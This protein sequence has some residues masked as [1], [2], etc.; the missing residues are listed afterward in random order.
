MR[1]G[2]SVSLVHGGI[3]HVGKYLT[4]RRCCP[5]KDDT[6]ME[7]IMGSE[8]ADPAAGPEVGKVMVGVSVVQISPGRGCW[9]SAFTCSLPLSLP[10]SLLCAFIHSANGNEQY[11]CGG[12][13][14]QP[15]HF[16]G[17]LKHQVEEES[18]QRPCG[19]ETGQVWKT[20]AGFRVKSGGVG[21]ERRRKEE[22]KK[23]EGDGGR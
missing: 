5:R 13:R 20:S 9:G 2:S 6:G 19:R 11:P 17:G 18:E 14:A 16:C 15:L 22:R 1:T 3:R 7:W 4:Q 10:S 21:W 8:P 23:G 12:P